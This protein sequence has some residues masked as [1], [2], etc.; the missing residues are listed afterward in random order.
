MAELAPMAEEAKAAG[1]ISSML[2]ESD[3]H[4]DLQQA[5]GEGDEEEGGEAAAAGGAAEAEAE[6]EAD[7][8]G[9]M[10]DD[11]AAGAAETYSNQDA[12]MQ[13]IADAGE[14]ER[15]ESIRASRGY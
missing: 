14:S 13:A 6:A 7:A 8:E 15:H 3:D 12:M 5:G 10:D 2:V 11:E 1:A 4:P 9:A